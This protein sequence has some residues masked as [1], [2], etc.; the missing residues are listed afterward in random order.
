MLATRCRSCVW[1]M[2]SCIASYFLLTVLIVVSGHTEGSSG[3]SCVFCGHSAGYCAVICVDRHHNTA[4]AMALIG[5][6]ARL[7]VQDK[8]GSTALMYATWWGYKEVATA[9]VDAGNYQSAAY[10]QAQST[11]G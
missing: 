2:G 4:V 9:L 5:A 11:P 3:N 8:E 6:G 1:H 10:Q 7:D